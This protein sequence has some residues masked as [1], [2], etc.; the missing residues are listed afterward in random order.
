MTVS[1]PS[2]SSCTRCRRLAVGAGPRRGS[3]RGLANQRGKVGHHEAGC[4]VGD[5]AERQLA[6]GHRSQQHF[7]SA[8][9]VATSG[10]GNASSRSHKSGARSRGSRRSGS[11]EVAMNATPAAATAARS[12]ARISVDTGSA[13]S[14]SNASISVISKYSAAVAH[15]GHRGRH[16]RE[17]VS[18]RPRR[19][20]PGRRARPASDRRRPRAP[21]SPCRR[22]PDRTPARRGSSRRPGSAA[23]AARRAPA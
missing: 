14:G 17:P 21:A 3:Q 19:P 1:A 9:R 8:V 13:D 23:S 6:G 12:S 22:R 11:A 5:V 16:L 2:R 15:R 20:L 10:S 7:N 4:A 18:R